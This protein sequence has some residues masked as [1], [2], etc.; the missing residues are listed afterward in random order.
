MVGKMFDSKD[1]R[2]RPLVPSGMSGRQNVTGYPRRI[3]GVDLRLD[4]DFGVNSRARN[5]IRK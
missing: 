5:I 2:G 4:L 1:R 3:I